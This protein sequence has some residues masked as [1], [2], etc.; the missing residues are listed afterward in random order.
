MRSVTA[1]TTK[2]FTMAAENTRVL[3][4][5][6]PNTKK[7]RENGLDHKHK[8]EAVELR[9]KTK[10]VNK[11]WCYHELSNHQAEIGNSILA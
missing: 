3:L 2:A 5:I 1:S 7:G 8:L 4:D 9:Q 6:T 11:M 10:S